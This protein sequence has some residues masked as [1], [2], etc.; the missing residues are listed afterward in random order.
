MEALDA[1]VFLLVKIGRIFADIIASLVDIRLVVGLMKTNP[2]EYLKSC[3]LLR[4]T[5]NSG[6][7]SKLGIGHVEISRELGRIGIAKI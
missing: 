4:C 6:K 1:L 2:S 7:I 3:R 5:Y